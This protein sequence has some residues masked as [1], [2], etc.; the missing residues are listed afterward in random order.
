MSQTT[1]SDHRRAGVHGS[2]TT[3]AFAAPWWLR[4]THAQTLWPSLFRPQPRPVFHR[5]RFE[6]TDGDF[7]DLDITDGDPQRT[8]VLL[9]G[10]EGSARSPYI[11]GMAQAIS[12]RGWRAVV[13]HFRGCSG[14]PNRLP[15]TYH[16]GDTGDVTALIQHLKA[17]QPAG[18]IALV[19]Y[20]LGGNVVLK[21]LGER[22]QLTGVAAAVAISV[23][24]V[25]SECARRLEHGFSRLYQWW[26]I[27]SLQR[28]LARKRNTPKAPVNFDHVHRYRTFTRFDHHVTAP[29]HGFRSSD[30]Y[31]QRASS[32]QFL[33]HIVTPTLIIQAQDDPFMTPEVLPA[34]EELSPAI[35]FEL[36]ATGGH[37]GFIHG[38]WPWTPCYWL[39]E[40]VPEF[41]HRFLE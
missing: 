41:L 8:V 39:E 33:S 30:D 20:S 6:L 1:A 36:S 5:Q 13:M 26:L 24:F 37:V 10:L 3:P 4:S 31:Y 28:S 7:V 15:R 18:Q 19:G 35:R 25:L 12:R 27:R 23:P 32:R 40:R 17:T 21:A 2:I 14:H 29:L 16:S 9:H 11:R 38:R 22:P 34:R